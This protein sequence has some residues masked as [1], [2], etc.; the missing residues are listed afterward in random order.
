MHPREV[1]LHQGEEGL[2]NSAARARMH[3]LDIARL[4]KRATEAVLFYI[5]R[6]RVPILLPS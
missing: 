6:P 5:A 4:L 3:D 1:V 2:A